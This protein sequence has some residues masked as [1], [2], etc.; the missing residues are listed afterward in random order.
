[1]GAATVWSVPLVISPSMAAGSFLVGAFGQSCVLFTRQ[2]LIVEI[3]FENEDDFVRNLATLRAE[4]R[5]GLAI[6]VPAG[7]IKGTF[8]A[9]AATAARK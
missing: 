9:T 4:E 1:L 7:L 5:V 2:L 3:A 8:T 6:P